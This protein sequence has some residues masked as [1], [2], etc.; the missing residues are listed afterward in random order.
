MIIWA[1]QHW[2]APDSFFSRLKCQESSLCSRTRAD[3]PRIVRL[4]ARVGPPKSPKSP[5][6]STH[7]FSLSRP[8]NELP[9]HRDSRA[10]AHLLKQAGAGRSKITASLLQS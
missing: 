1:V 4:V 3:G 8:T 10:G 6:S 9:L 7:S 2:I 5:K